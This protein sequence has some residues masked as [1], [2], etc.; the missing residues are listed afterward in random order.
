MVAS[1]SGKLKGISRR[2]TNK[3]KCPLFWSDKDVETRITGLFRHYKLGNKIFKWQMV[4]YGDHLYKNI[5]M[6]FTKTFGQSQ[7]SIV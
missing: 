1:K 3:K 5:Q 2:N 4:K 7:V 6:K